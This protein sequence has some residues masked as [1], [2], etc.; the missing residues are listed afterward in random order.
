MI[1]VL[2][3]INIQSAYNAHKLVFDGGAGRQLYLSL[4]VK[5]GSPRKPDLARSS[6]LSMATTTASVLPVRVSLQDQAG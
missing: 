1:S 4:G 5:S 6:S 3:S 2:C